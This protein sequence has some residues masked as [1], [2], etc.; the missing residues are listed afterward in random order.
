MSDAAPLQSKKRSRMCFMIFYGASRLGEVF[1]IVVCFLD[2]DWLAHKVINS[3][4]HEYGGVS[5]D[6]SSY[7]HSTNIAICTLKVF[8][9]LAQGIECLFILDCVGERFI[10]TIS[11]EFGSVY[12][13]IAQ[14]PGCCGVNK[15]AELLKDTLLLVDG[16]NGKCSIGFLNYL[17]M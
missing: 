2:S 17:E 16:V 6:I 3:L 10:I 12:L 1:V 5:V 13:H 14:K 8:Y 4:S 9:P 7:A 15:H 11:Q